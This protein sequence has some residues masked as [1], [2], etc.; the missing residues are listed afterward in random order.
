MA[1]YLCWGADQMYGGLHGMF[2]LD[3]IEGTKQEANEVAYELS[4]TVIESYPEIYDELA[5]TYDDDSNEFAD[6]YSITYDVC[7]YFDCDAYYLV[8]LINEDK[9]AEYS[10]DDLLQKAY[11]MGVDDFVDSYCICE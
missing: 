8:W 7:D 10:I 11:T 3:I 1:R 6:G 5:D 4:C 2:E 9:C